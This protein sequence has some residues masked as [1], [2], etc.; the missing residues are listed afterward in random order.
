MNPEQQEPTTEAVAEEEVEDLEASELD[1]EDTKGG[2][3]SKWVN[4]S[5]FGKMKDAR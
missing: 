1:V 4:N 3:T 2:T 5:W